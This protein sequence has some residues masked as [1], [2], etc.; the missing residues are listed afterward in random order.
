MRNE[1][2]SEQEH[3][4]VTRGTKSGSATRAASLGS[5]K[6]H[7][8]RRTP[9][10]PGS[11]EAQARGFSQRKLDDLKAIYAEV[12]PQLGPVLP[13]GPQAFYGYALRDGRLIDAVYGYGSMTDL[14][15]FSHDTWKIL[16]VHAPA[17][18]VENDRRDN[19]PCC[20]HRPSRNHMRDWPFAYDGDEQTMSRVCEHLVYHPDLDHLAYIAHRF[21]T[22]H[23][24]HVSVHQCCPDRCCEGLIP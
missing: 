13:T 21:D 20:I 23:A 19:P 2:N 1:E 22:G 15:G 8:R 11:V 16:I 3:P 12:E 9:P 14:S 10:P 24:N 4:G 17:L 18:C 6:S 5:G 7:P